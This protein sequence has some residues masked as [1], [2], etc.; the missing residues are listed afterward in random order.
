MPV[1]N[2][3]LVSY[4]GSIVTEHGPA[5]VIGA[6]DDTFAVSRDGYRYTL[7]TETGETLSLV[8]R[9]SFAVVS[10]S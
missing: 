4:A 3:T 1:E 5:T 6:I 2:G 7:R 8:R 9:Q 10:M